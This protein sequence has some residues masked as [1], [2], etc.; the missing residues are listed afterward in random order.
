MSMLVF[1]AKVVLFVLFAPIFLAI[2]AYA[3]LMIL[4]ELYSSWM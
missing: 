3:V 4:Y 2:I 1:A